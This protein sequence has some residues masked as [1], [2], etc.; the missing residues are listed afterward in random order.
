LPLA[1]K[2]ATPITVKTSNSLELKA[3]VFRKNIFAVLATENHEFSKKIRIFGQG[4]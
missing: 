4:I 1:N 2:I 3:S